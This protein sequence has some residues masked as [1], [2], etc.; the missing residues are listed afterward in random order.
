MRKYVNGTLMR[1]GYTTGSCAAAAAKA[2]LKYLCTGEMPRTVNITTL[3]GKKL[4]LIVESAS[5]KDGEAQRSAVCAIK[6]DAGDDPDITDGALVFAEVC[7]KK[8]GECSVPGVSVASRESAVIGVRGAFGIPEES[9]ATV[10]SGA[11]FAERIVIDGGVGVGRVTRPGLDQPV[12]AAAINSGPRKM[13]AQAVCEAADECGFAP[14]CDEYLH[15]T[16]F[17]PDG[18]ALARRTFNT[19]LGIE[20]GISILGTTGIV[21]PMSDSALAATIEAEVSVLAAEGHKKLM[22]NLGNYGEDFTKNVLK[23]L[24]KP[25]VKCSNFIDAAMDAAVAHGMDSLLIIGH[26]GK[27]VKLGIAMFN[28]HSGNGDGRLETL[29]ACA[30][31]SGADGD[32]V[33]EILSCA[34]TEAALD[35]LEAAGLFDSA[36]FELRSRIERAISRRMPEYIRTEFI[37]FGGRIG[38]W[39]ELFA[40][41]GAHAMAE[42]WK[43][44]AD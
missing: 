11:L 9:G 1:Y 6:K 41:D 26:I 2:A 39:R 32:A 7:I 33:R 24:P 44:I 4:E 43:K 34:T 8:S 28:T 15:V 27:L 31:V 16:V 38:A 30:A 25:S 19:M 10:E 3:S 35:V 23:L 22:V 21:E 17:V 5:V 29:A 42:F 14:G 37:C 18:E 13:I 20:G 12:G 36:L 40:S